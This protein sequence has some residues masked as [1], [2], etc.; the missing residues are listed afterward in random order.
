MLAVAWGITFSHADGDFDEE[1]FERRV[2]IVNARD[3][4]RA[5]INEEGSEVLEVTGLPALEAGIAQMLADEGLLTRMLEATTVQVLI[6]ALNEA[7]R[8]IDVER[9]LLS[10]DLSDL[11]RTHQEVE[12]QLGDLNNRARHIRDT[13]NSYAQRIGERAAVHFEDYGVRMI[14]EWNA[15]WETLEIREML[16]L[17]DVAAATFSDARKKELTR[18]VSGRVGHYLERR[19]EQWEEEVLE[20]LESDMEEMSTALDEEVQDFV[21]KL[22]EVQ[23]LIVGD[24]M[25]EV[26]DVQERRVSKTIQILYGVLAFD[27]NQVT[28]SLM[29][30]SWKGF[31]GRMVSEVLAV[32]IAGVAASFFT[33]PVGWTVF[34]GVLII[35]GIFL[36]SVGRRFM[37]NR[38]RDKIRDQLRVKFVGAA[39]EIKSKI[40]QSIGSQFEEPSGKLLSALQAEI[41]QVRDQLN[42][43]LA[44][45]QAGEEKIGAERS[46]LD[47]V[48]GH[49]DGLFEQISREIY[50]RELTDVELQRLRRRQGAAQ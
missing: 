14:G 38:V 41:D 6:P 8:S 37:L 29:G 40:Q 13:F 23:A 45:K 11:E 43:V 42:S 5:R 27:P 39:P 28:G 31:F 46:R 2:F 18:E 10:R 30:G 22:D 25:P 12:G 3:A 1:L 15:D 9:V 49:L 48:E 16:R 24:Q 21:V 33:G 7:N 36:H 44:K 17:W 26:L 35:E 32:V 34:F 19:M 47:A 4:L 50:G 20:H